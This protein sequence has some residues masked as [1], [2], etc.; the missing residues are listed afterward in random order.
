MAE[1]R[2]PQ[3]QG[4]AILFMILAWTFVGLRCYVR[5]VMIKGFGMD[6]WL[7]VISL[8]FF[9]IY[10]TFVSLGVSKGTGQHLVDLP[11]E[12]IPIAVKWWWCC[13]LSY[14]ASTAFLKV[15]I[16]I[17]LARICVAK[18][19]RIAIWVVG[20]STA[21]YSI[22][23][24]FV[25][26]FQCNPAPYFWTQYLGA[27]GT[28]LPSSWITITTY[29]HGAVS[30]VS[31]WTLGILPVFLLWDLQMNVRTK[32]MVGLILSLGAVGSVSTIV[33]LPYIQQLGLKDF[34]Y[35]TTDVAIWSTVEPGIGLTASSMA[36]LR[37]LFAD[38]FSRSKL[39]GGTTPAGTLGR[40]TGQWA[41]KPREHQHIHSGSTTGLTSSSKD[42]DDVEL[43]YKLRSDIKDS[44]NLGM[45]T[46]VIASREDAEL[47][48]DKSGN[49][50]WTKSA[51]SRASEENGRLGSRGG[52]SDNMLEPVPTNNMPGQGWGIT[53]TMSVRIGDER[54]GSSKSGRGGGFM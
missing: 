31:D 25:I 49:K 16:A 54:N 39:F 15:S 2:G 3:V 29:T 28:C 50:R 18:P 48:R 53:K 4:V 19:Q 12:N 27:Q 42:D 52:L 35:A 21:L 43:G 44:K 17:F 22:F 37:P 1:N 38:F 51:S 8:I 23:Y 46:T 41:G 36:T 10:C 47:K 32:I 14:V 20:V 24:F 40:T 9:T 26:V 7:A 45:T 33:R 11:P 6:D 5:A 13:E 30:V 34:L